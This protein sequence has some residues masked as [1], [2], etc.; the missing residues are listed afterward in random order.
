MHAVADSKDTIIELLSDLQEQLFSN[1][2]QEYIVLEGDAK[3]YEVLQSLK[4]E[5]RECFKWRIPFAGDWHMLMNCQHAL[6]KS[7]L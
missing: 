5:Y 3:L 6:I 7:I 2:S 4:F 1:E